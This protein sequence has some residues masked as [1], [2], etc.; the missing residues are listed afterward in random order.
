MRMDGYISAGC[1]Q[2]AKLFDCQVGRL[3]PQLREAIV[4]IGLLWLEVRPSNG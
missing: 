2:R 3:D 4:N 1:V